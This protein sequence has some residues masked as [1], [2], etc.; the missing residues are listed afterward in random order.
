MAFSRTYANAPSAKAMNMTA[1]NPAAMRLPI[2]QSFTS[3]DSVCFRRRAR[4][5]AAEAAANGRRTAA[6]VGEMNQPAYVQDEGH[7]S[8]AHDGGAGGNLHVPIE[9][10]ERLNHCLVRADYAIHHQPHP[11]VLVPHNHDL[12]DL[13]RVSGDPEQLAHVDV[14]N[15][16]SAHRDH[17]PS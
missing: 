1:A 4:D 17:V 9:P 7:R 2:L 13:Q 6:P 15:Q 14:W 16:L 3:V 11:R 10:A 5:F 8:V 12:L